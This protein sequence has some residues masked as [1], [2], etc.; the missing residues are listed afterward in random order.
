MA[1]LAA[2]DPTPA[3]P[4]RAAGLDD[5]CLLWLALDP[6]AGRLLDEGFAHWQGDPV[7]VEP[8][9]VR[10]PV[11]RRGVSHGCVPDNRDRRPG[12]PD[13]GPARLPDRLLHGPHRVPEDAQA[14]RGGGRDA[15]VGR[16]PGEDLRLAHHPPGEWGARVG[17]VT[18]R[19]RELGISRTRQL[20]AGAHL[21]VAPLH[22]PAG[23]RR[24]R[25]DPELTVGGIGRSRWSSRRHLPARGT[26]PRLSSAGSRLDLHLFAV[27]RRL[28]RAR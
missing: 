6:A 10:E 18:V 23:L 26:A 19:I 3:P 25:A 21:S 9:R 22:D 14:P 13:R 15:A 20:L 27:A 17:A 1:L 8:G 28:H 24:A 11:R 5:G 12:D 16:L 2:P 7:L 4:G